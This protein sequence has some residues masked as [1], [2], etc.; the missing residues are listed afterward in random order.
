MRRVFLPLLCGGALAVGL[1]TQVDAGS[2]NLE[3]GP[4]TVEILPFGLIHEVRR[5]DLSVPMQVQLYNPGNATVRLL[6]LS[7]MT[8]EGEILSQTSLEDL[9]LQGD[10]GVVREIY[11]DME[12]VN[13]DFS[14]RHTNR[15]YIPLEDRAD[16]GPEAEAEGMR[17]VIDGVEA[18]KTTGAPQLYDAPFMVD[19]DRL[20]GFEPQVGDLVPY[21]I[22]V[23]WN[24]GSGNLQQTSFATTISLIRPFLPPPPGHWSYGRGV[25]AWI[26]GDMHVHNCRDEAING[27]DSCAAES[28]NITG[29]FSNAQLKNQFQAIG[30]DFFSS[31]THSYCINSDTEFNA[32]LTE[33]STLSD[34]SF[35]MLASTEVSGAELGPQTGNDSADLLCALG[36]GDYDVHHMGAHN[37]TSR[38]LGGRDGFLDFCDSPM[39]DQ[40]A[41][42]QAINAEGGF[43]VAHHPASDFWAYNSTGW[44]HGQESQRVWGVEV[45]N[46]SEG[47]NFWQPFHR[48]WWVDRMTEGMILFP[49]SGSDTHDSAYNFG[50]IHTFVPG[51]LDQTTLTSALRGGN[52]YISNGPFLE[53]TL[54]DGGSRGL[55]MGGKVAV[56]GSR[57]P[58]NFPV[59]IDVSYNLDLTGSTLTVYRGEVGVG[60]TIIH[61]ATGLTGAG[62][63][64]V[65]DFLPSSSCW[66]RAEVHNNTFSEAAVTTPMFIT[67]R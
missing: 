37:I 1:L 45:W 51:V 58:P 21:E 43:A 11:M 36:F 56:P 39:G 6:D 53:A 18:L 29:S 23:R 31:T 12:R 66:Y 33:S 26:T 17:R 3:F 52:S 19:L 22:R 47:A 15:L 50:A 62:T 9:P 14:H 7:I 42:T 30:F 48:N 25:G 16:I 63:L 46:G 65:P 67:L 20:F 60:E 4:S 35:V 32:V 41:N 34:P 2:K 40:G 54:S 27:C 55:P 49:Y 5:T 28:T 38:K 64:Q 24:D 61:S 13:P 8:P 44:M 57:I 10:G 59:F